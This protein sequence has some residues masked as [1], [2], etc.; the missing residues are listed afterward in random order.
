MPRLE[1]WAVRALANGAT[2]PPLGL[3][4]KI[5]GLIGV[6]ATGSRSHCTSA[7]SSSFGSVLGVGPLVLI[8]M[9]DLARYS[10]K[11]N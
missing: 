4:L 6:G 5:R 10:R 3:V 9:L 11:N 8:I 1:G 2:T 7:G